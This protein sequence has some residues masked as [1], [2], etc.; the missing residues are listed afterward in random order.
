MFLLAPSFE[1][2]AGH[3]FTQAAFRRRSLF[4]SAQ[5]LVEQVVG[6][7]NQANEDIGNDLR[8]ASLNIGVIG[9]IGRMG[10]RSQAS[11]EQSLSGA[12]VPEAMTAS[13]KEVAVVFQKLLEAGAGHIQKFDFGFLGRAAG[14]AAF[15]DVLFP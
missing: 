7:V 14:L 13:A 15:E 10:I 11:Y 8:G 9:L 6:L 4:Q 1:A 12:F 2:G 3:A 5:L